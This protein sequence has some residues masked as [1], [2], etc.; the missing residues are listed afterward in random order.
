MSRYLTG[1]DPSILVHASADLIARCSTAAI[2][3]RLTLARPATS[4]VGG[5]LA[6]LACSRHRSPSPF[7]ARLTCENQSAPTR[8]NAALALEWPKI[9]F[10]IFLPPTKL[11][12]SFLPAVSCQAGS[13]LACQHSGSFVVPRSWPLLNRLKAVEAGRRLC[14]GMADNLERASAVSA[15]LS[16]AQN[17]IEA[18]SARCS[19]TCVCDTCFCALRACLRGL[20]GILDGQACRAGHHAG[21]G[22]RSFQEANA[23]SDEIPSDEIQVTVRSP[24]RY[25]TQGLSYWVARLRFQL[26]GFELLVCRMRDC[27]LF[28]TCHAYR[29]DCAQLRLS[30]LLYILI[31]RMSCWR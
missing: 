1:D 31:Q 29:L 19:A 28:V 25:I 17:S 15:T 8:N 14:K 24:S 11:V 9:G 13:F 21:A 22:G 20:R 23:P 4:F 10:H 6:G 12:H 5:G 2:C 27:A 3:H 26:G 16:E 7:C 30:Y 18:P